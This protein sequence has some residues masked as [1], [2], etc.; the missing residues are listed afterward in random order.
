MTPEDKQCFLAC[1]F[2]NYHQLKDV[3][4][5][6][7]ITFLI[8]IE[9]GYQHINKFKDKVSFTPPDIIKMSY[10]VWKHYKHLQQ[11]PGYIGV[12]PSVIFQRIVSCM[13]LLAISTDH[14]IDY[15]KYYNLETVLNED[16]HWFN[17]KEM[18]E[19]IK[20]G[21]RKIDLDL[22]NATI[23]RNKPVICS[24]MDAGANPYIDPDDGT[25][26]SEAL[27]LLS[28]DAQIGF[29]TYASY[30]EDYHLQKNMSQYSLFQMIKFLYC[31]ACASELYDVIDNY[32]KFRPR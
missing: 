14:N 26:E 18:E 4:N 6:G 16:E 10:E 17:P 30:W 23:K 13:D 2:A 7:S 27:S 25:E 28:A 12:N 29:N 8:D 31:T 32:S 15:H 21:F 5:I 1:F 3:S 22:I 9:K 20:S 19:H 11:L 24:L